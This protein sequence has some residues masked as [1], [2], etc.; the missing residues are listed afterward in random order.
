MYKIIGADGKEYG[1]ISADQ[2]R[3]WIV[4]GRLS[5]TT[6]VQ[7]DGS[8]EWKPLSGFHEFSI[9]LSMAGGTLH[10]Q[11]IAPA[12]AAKTSGLAIAS[13][14]LGILGVFTCGLSAIVG[15]VLG[16]I[17]QIKINQSQGR[18]SGSGLAI[19]GICTSV[20]SLAL[21]LLILPGLL[22]PALTRANQKAVTINCVNNMKQMGLSMVMYA[23]DHTN[24]LP[25]AMAWSDSVSNYVGSTKIFH[26]PAD[27]H[28]G[29]SYAFNKN[30]DRQ[31]LK[32][33]N[34][35]TVLLFESETGWNASGG[36]EIMVSS[37]HG[38]DGCNIVFA[39]GSVRTVRGAQLDRLRWDP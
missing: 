5:A 31:N 14:V 39:D 32:Q 21:V 34:P 16:I 25:A 22:L 10:G 3:Q 38:R 7:P 1:P 17:S 18:L 30:L 2:M 11:A 26:C 4:Q 28:P 9:A 13:L 29:C 8:S 36:R 35:G 6:L 15:L 12:P 19:A 33:I 24:Q 37:R 20:V 27:S 23:D